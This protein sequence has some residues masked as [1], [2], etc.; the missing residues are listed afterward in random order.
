MISTAIA[1]LIL[2][3]IFSIFLAFFLHVYVT[4][5]DKEST[6]SDE[7]VRLNGQPLVFKGNF[8]L[9]EEEYEHL[10]EQNKEG[11]EYAL[12]SE[13]SYYVCDQC[14]AENFVKIGY[15]LDPEMMLVHRC[16]CCFTEHPIECQKN[17]RLRLI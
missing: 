17:T 16:N 14:G 9:T 6:L 5:K 3:G 2:L 4:Y 7:I 13:T 12:M 8:F 15:D 1:C 10:P 11:W